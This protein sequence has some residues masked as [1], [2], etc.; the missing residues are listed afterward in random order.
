M[1]GNLSMGTS[2]SPSPSQALPPLRKDLRL[3]AGGAEGENRG[4]WKIHDPLRQRFIVISQDIVDLLSQW[5]TGTVERLIERVRSRFG[6]ELSSE[7]VHEVVEFLS[8][9]QLLHP[10]PGISRARAHQHRQ[11]S[12]KSWWSR[13]IHGY[14]FFRIPLVRPDRFLRATAPL[15]SVFYQRSFWLL[16]AVLAA[17]GLVLVSHQW[18]QFVTT[19]PQMF[20]IAGLVAFALSLVIVKTLHELGHG[21]TAVRM[22]S[23]VASMGVA[24]IVMM[25]V[26]YTDTT[27]A[28]RLDT[29]RQRVMIDVAGMAVE[30]IVAVFATLLWV[31]LPDGPLRYVAFS[32]ASTGWVLSLLI[33]L[34]PLMRFDGYYLFSDLLGI[35]NLQERSFAMGRWW[36]RELLFGYGDEIPESAGISR[37]RLLVGFAFMV[38]IY[39]FFL[40]LGIALLVYHFFFKALGIVLFAI[41]L[42]WF[43]VL[44]ILR[45]VRVWWQRRGQCGARTWITGL[46]CLTLL[47][48]LVIPLPSTI[49]IP[50]MLSAAQQ[51]YSFAPRPA[52]VSEVLVEEGQQV[53]QGQPLLRLISPLLEQ[54]LVSAMERARLLQ[55]RLDRRSADRQDRSASLV[56]ARELIMEQQT[57]DGL[58]AEREQ[59][60]VHAPLSGTVMQIGHE[61]H[62]GRWVD[63]TT[64]LV[65][66]AR[67]AQ[68]KARG[69]INSHDLERVQLGDHGE[70]IDDSFRLDPLPARISYIAASASEV[71]DNWPLASIY[72]GRVA[73][74][75]ED[76]AAWPEQAV[77]DISATIEDQAPLLQAPTEL[78][79]EIQIQGDRQ[80][81][82]V[83]ILQRIAQVLVRE[84]TA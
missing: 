6:R 33:N 42:A 16:L 20:N 30:I 65:L 46:I 26:L 19:L 56:L 28:W 61:L 7:T 49:R 76:N 81:M 35:A 67:P 64:P 72:G 31:F 5:H 69:Y 83:R 73:S 63:A 80:S 9:N 48:L 54:E 10:Q 25:P 13:L 47:A 36:L 14:L 23:R 11:S 4:L 2:A 12:Q 60:I 53:E 40:F 59:L 8:Q 38:W 66:V 34:N 24:L 82:A 37:R 58:Q 41:E 57:I 21:Y 74:R 70:F 43:I 55:S 62:V 32:L 15:T 84:S 3:I 29:R 27:D 44:P 77:F 52:Q 78:R 50:A 22:G 79:G 68:W 51:Q 75:M 1:D 71:L 18:E 45:E 17:A 39:R